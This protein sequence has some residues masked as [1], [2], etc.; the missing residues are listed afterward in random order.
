MRGFDSA[1]N[2]RRRLTLLP[3][4]TIEMKFGDAISLLDAVVGMSPGR[5]G[6]FTPVNLSDAGPDRGGGGAVGERFAE[7][8]ELDTVAA[9]QQVLPR[10]TPTTTISW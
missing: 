1:C 3:N 2:V 5:T 9:R 8:G 10:R 6:V 7:R 4:G